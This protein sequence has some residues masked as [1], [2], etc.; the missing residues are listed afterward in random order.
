MGRA[1]RFLSVLAGGATKTRDS[2]GRMMVALL[3]SMVDRLPGL[4]APFIVIHA[5]L[6]AK[7]KK[8]LKDAYEFVEFR[9]VDEAKYQEA[10]KTDCRYFFLEAFNPKND[11]DKIIVLDADMLCVGSPNR[12]IYQ[13]HGPI[14]MWREPRRACWN[15]GCMVVEKSL[16]TQ[17]VYDAVVAHKN[18]TEFG[19]DQG[20]INSFFAGKIH[21][22]PDGTQAF[23][24]HDTTPSGVAFLHFIYKPFARKDI[25]G[26]NNKA[27]VDLLKKYMGEHWWK[28]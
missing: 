23:V 2:Y 27:C 20:V 16:M 1:V 18:T 13:S 11:C 24:E 8:R 15:S 4:S 19:R 14:A 10:G 9:R 5:E 26:K 17:E 28:V 7:E 6:T 12:L 25:A 21:A 3:R 22:L